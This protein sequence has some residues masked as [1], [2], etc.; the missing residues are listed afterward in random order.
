[1]KEIKVNFRN[2]DFFHHS[3]FLV[4]KSGREDNKHVE[5]VKIIVSKQGIKHYKHKLTP[6]KQSWDRKVDVFFIFSL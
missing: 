5:V 1:M 3:K 4:Q 2:G 6:H